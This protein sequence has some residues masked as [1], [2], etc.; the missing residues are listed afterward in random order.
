MGL[1]ELIFFLNHEHNQR[2]TI[3][4]ILF[5]YCVTGPFQSGIWFNNMKG[6]QIVHKERTSEQT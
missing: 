4:K 2:E 5:Y 6:G 3:K 1:R